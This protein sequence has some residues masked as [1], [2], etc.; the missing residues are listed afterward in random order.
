MCFVKLHYMRLEIGEDPNVVV[1][2]P[3]A[4]SSPRFAEFVAK[5]SSSTYFVFVEQMTV[6]ECLTFSNALFLW[7]CTHLCFSLIVSCC[8]G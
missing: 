2:Q 7:F 1:A 5:D 4:R 8:G 3:P 6:C